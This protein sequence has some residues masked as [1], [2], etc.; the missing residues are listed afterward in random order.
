MSLGLHDFEGYKARLVARGF[1]QAYDTESI[2][3]KDTYA[4]TGKITT[5]CTLLS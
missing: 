2:D 4:P 3:Y 5:F 1:N